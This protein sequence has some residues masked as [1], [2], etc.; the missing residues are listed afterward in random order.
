MVTI[1][2]TII[3]VYEKQISDEKF[4]T[5]M[6]SKKAPEYI[7]DDLPGLVEGTD[8]IQHKKIMTATKNNIKTTLLNKK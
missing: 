1:N 4:S 3:K 6:K 2:Y 7:E 8:L 5:M